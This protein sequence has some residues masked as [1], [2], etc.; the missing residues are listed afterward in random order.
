[1]AD[2]VSVLCAPPQRAMVVD[3]ARRRRRRSPPRNGEHDS[4]ARHRASPKTDDFVAR[5]RALS[6]TSPPPIGGRQRARAS[7]AVESVSAALSDLVPWRR[8]QA[9]RDAPAAGP[10]LYAAAL[11]LWAWFSPLLVVVA[12]LIAMASAS[13]LTSAALLCLSAASLLSCTRN[14]Q[15]RRSLWHAGAVA[16]GLYYAHSPRNRAIADRLQQQPHGR[17]SGSAHGHPPSLTPWLPHG[18]LRTL[19][20]FIAF[21]RPPAVNYQRVWFRAPAWGDSAPADGQSRTS[22]C[23][24]EVL[25]LDVALPDGGHDPAKPLFVVLHGLNGGSAEPYVLDFVA[26]SLGRGCT[27]VVMIA[28]GL[29][30]TRLVSGVPFNGARTTDV[31]SCLGLLRAAAAPTTPLVGVGFSMGAIIL[32]NYCGVAGATNPLACAI[33]FSGCYDAVVGT[34]AYGAR[35]W[36]PWLAL[37]LKRTFLSTNGSNSDVLDSGRHGGSVDVDAAASSAVVTIRDFDRATVVPFFGFASVEEYYRAMSL[38]HRNKARRVAVPLLAV[39]ACDDPIAD[40]A[41]YAPTISVGNKQLWFLITRSGGHVGWAE[42]SRPA[43]HGWSFMRHVAWE[44]AEAVLAVK[45]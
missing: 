32:A 10:A 14:W 42:G 16:P 7:S 36:H 23:E 20:P 9:H 12:P 11:M 34:P 25:A 6:N 22:T 41:S 21:A 37:E 13:S 33:S 1:M 30:G 39:H 2:D 26:A 19:Y 35:L 43:R 38:G 45:P 5:L 40:S 3:E 29:G 15:L 17:L 44:F 18:D 8:A 27:C 24:E 31:A 28:R 4:S